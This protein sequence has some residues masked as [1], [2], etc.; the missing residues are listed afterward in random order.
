MLS[1]ERIRF[2]ANGSNGSPKVLLGFPAT[3]SRAPL[4]SSDMPNLNYNDYGPIILIM[5]IGFKKN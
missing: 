2:G 5:K 1:D 4:N 3:E